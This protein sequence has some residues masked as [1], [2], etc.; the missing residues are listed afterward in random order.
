PEP[1]PKP[2]PKPTPEPTPKPKPEPKPEPAPEPKPRPKPK[3]DP[4]PAPQ[5]EPAPTPQ[6]Q[7][8]PANPGSKPAR[9][10]AGAVGSV[11][12]T[13]PSYRAKLRA[14]L[15]QH[16]TYPRR[17]RRLRQEGTVVLYFVMARDGRV[18]HWDIRQSSGH[19]LLDQAV[20]QL[21]RSAN[22]MPALP[23]NTQMQ[24]LALTVPIRFH[25]R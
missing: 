4:E 24:R 21:I 1:P 5:P 8:P 12:D 22:P 20:K 7:A 25:L 18:L 16:K 3:P 2:E 6:P 23:D 17:A 15:I 14:W 13:P 19:E 9:G 11:A 10:Q